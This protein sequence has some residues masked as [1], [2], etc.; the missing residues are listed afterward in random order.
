MNFS[1]PHQIFQEY[2][3]SPFFYCFLFL[4]ITESLIWYQPIYETR[5]AIWSKEIW[6][7][8]LIL[9]LAIT[10]FSKIPVNG[11]LK[12][13]SLVN[14]RTPLLQRSLM[15]GI[16]WALLVI[17]I[18][19]FI[20]GLYVI[21]GTDHP[22]TIIKKTE[23]ER[24]HV[25]GIIMEAII[26]FMNYLCYLPIKRSIKKQL[27][28]YKNYDKGEEFAFAFPFIWMFFITS[29]IVVAFINK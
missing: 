4:L 25:A 3:H 11:L 20:I 26:P 16:I 15:G 28:L 7:S 9:M 1:K 14:E 21:L 22:E 2:I 24:D 12:S 29:L 18:I 17:D 23:F 5:E 27:G 10:F 13:H 6:I 8:L 19:F